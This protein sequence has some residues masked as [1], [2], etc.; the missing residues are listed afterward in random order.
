MQTSICD[1]PDPPPLK[2]SA[3]MFRKTDDQSGYEETQAGRDC[4][5]AA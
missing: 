4:H 5:D 2:R 3:V 1:D